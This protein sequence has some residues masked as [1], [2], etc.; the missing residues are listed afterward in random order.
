MRGIQKTYKLCRKVYQS[1]FIDIAD[2]FIGYIQSLD[3]DEIQQMV[4][5]IK[6]NG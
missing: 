4:D 3:L 2:I 5:D 1:I 6:S